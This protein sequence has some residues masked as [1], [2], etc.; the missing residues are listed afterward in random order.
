MVFPRFWNRNYGCVFPC[1]WKI[2]QSNTCIEYVGQKN[3]RFS[4]NIFEQDVRYGIKSRGFT[5]L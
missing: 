3:Y 1:F 4:R 5:G 2:T